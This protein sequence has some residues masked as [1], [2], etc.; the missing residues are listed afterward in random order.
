MESNRVGGGYARAV[1]TDKMQLVRDALPEFL[2]TKRASEAFADDMVWDF[3]EFSGWIEDSEYYGPHGF[4]EQMER[5][6][7]PF[8]D[9]TMEVTELVDIGGDDVLVLGTQR[10]TL[11]EGGAVVE[12]PIAQIL[13]TQDDKLKRIRIFL[14]HEDARAAAGLDQ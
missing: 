6:T 12:M 8:S 13:T 14:T 1:A 7:A 9:W 10:G 2:K 5:W 4:D 11:K 3:S